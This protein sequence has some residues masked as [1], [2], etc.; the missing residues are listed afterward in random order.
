MMQNAGLLEGI[1]N[2]S[3]GIG[4]DIQ[5]Y[6]TGS[7]LDAT[8]RNGG[9]AFKGDAGGDITYSITPQ[10]KVNFTVNTD[11][12]ET[13]VDQRQINLTRFPLRFPEK[14]GFFLEG[15]TFFD[16]SGEQTSKIVPFFSRRIGLDANGQPQRI[17][18]GTKVTGQVGL[19]DI[20]LLQVRTGNTGQLPGEDFTVL[21][22]KR[23]FFLQSYAGMLYTRR[24]QRN[25]G[26]PDRNTIGLDF[27]LATSRF[28][29]NQ[30][31]HLNGYYIWTT[32]NGVS[33][34]TAAYGMRLE[35][36]NDLWLGRMVVREI[37]AGYDPAVG[38]IERRNAR[39]FNPQF[40]FA[41]RPASMTRVVRRFVF[42]ADP[43]ITTDLHNRVTTRQVKLTAFQMD[44]QSGESV[45]IMVT[46][47]RERLERDFEISRGVILPSGPTY[48]FTRYNIRVSTSSRRLVSIT[49][50]YEGGN[51]YN[52]H[53]RKVTANLGLRPRTGVLINVDNEWIRTELEQGSFSTS[54]L[55]LNVNNQFS[56]W[57]S[58]V[59]NLQYDSVSR[60]LGWQFRYR[61]IVKPGNDL[62]FVYSQN[63][64]DDPS[65]SLTAL[66]RKAATKLLY[67][68]RF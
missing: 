59:N 9:S 32:P 67:T 65:G 5:P 33:D 11:F 44:L 64:L 27:L 16:F 34:Q 57:M 46:P 41:P 38:F 7:Y 43:E 4:L 19:Y 47:T 2:V 15:T 14:R 25:T 29:G 68:H 35:Y 39:W 30:K 13:E 8:G 61:W 63:W 37:Q 36:P 10:L 60:I 1:S 6:M 48:D 66:D 52:G 62:Y 28:L 18:F 40:Q 26:L 42:G 55:R 50:A 54:V 31:L 23:R 22:T 21:R 12:A 3:Q 20:G 53:Q 51:F 56:P 17:D 24:A 49:T 58:V 45:Q